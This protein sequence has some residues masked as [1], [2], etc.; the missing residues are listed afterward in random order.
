MGVGQISLKKN[1]NN[2]LSQSAQLLWRPLKSHVELS[3]ESTKSKLYGQH[4]AGFSPIKPEHTW[5]CTAGMDEGGCKRIHLEYKKQ[6]QKQIKATIWLAIWRVLPMT[7]EKVV[8]SALKKKM[9]ER[10]TSFKVIPS[11]DFMNPERQHHVDRNT[12]CNY[13]LLTLY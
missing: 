6:K 12:H 3:L 4:K 13:T 5:P 11:L 7:N 8:A 2:K 10:K 1:K 9:K